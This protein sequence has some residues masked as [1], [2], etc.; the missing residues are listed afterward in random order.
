MRHFDRAKPLQEDFPA[1]SRILHSHGRLG[2]IWRH[3]PPE[4]TSQMR[5]IF[6]LIIVP[7]FTKSTL[8]S[9]FSLKN[10]LSGVNSIIQRRNARDFF[11]SL[12]ICDSGLVGTGL[13]SQDAPGR[14]AACGFVM[15]DK[16]TEQANL[17]REFLPR[18]S[19]SLWKAACS[20][21][22]RGLAADSRWP[23][24]A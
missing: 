22:P 23:A 18:F 20:P 3:K 1:N 16:L 9:A 12:G 21:A 24:G 7:Y 19:A 11:Q 13:M 2:V 15:L 6:S 8:D 17:P 14:F 5:T 4:Q 10:S